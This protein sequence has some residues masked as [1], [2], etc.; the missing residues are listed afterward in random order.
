V[1]RGGHGDGVNASIDYDY[2]VIWSDG[3]EISRTMHIFGVVVVGIGS[4]FSKE[5]S[6]VSFEICNA[7]ELVMDGNIGEALSSSKSDAEIDKWHV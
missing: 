5:R 3:A 6:P 7:D 1:R 2:V 4:E